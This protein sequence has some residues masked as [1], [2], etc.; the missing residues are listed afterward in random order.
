MNLQFSTADPRRAWQYI[1]RALPEVTKANAQPLLNLVGEQVRIGDPMM[2]GG[3]APVF[4]LPGSDEAAIRAAGRL[5]MTR[6]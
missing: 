3:T 6:K 5:L 2:Y 1:Q 4:P